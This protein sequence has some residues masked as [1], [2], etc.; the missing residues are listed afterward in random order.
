[1]PNK[2]RDMEG[3]LKE[4]IERLSLEQENQTHGEETWWKGFCLPKASHKHILP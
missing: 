2:P 4:G 1:M 3:W